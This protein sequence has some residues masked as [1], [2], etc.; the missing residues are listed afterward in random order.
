MEMTIKRTIRGEFEDHGE[1]PGIG[2]Q[3]YERGFDRDYVYLELEGFSFEAACLT[4]E[5]NLANIP[6]VV[7]ELPHEWAKK[8]KLITNLDVDE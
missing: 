5:H 4:R 8:L 7:I 1:H 3:I 6:R 2:F